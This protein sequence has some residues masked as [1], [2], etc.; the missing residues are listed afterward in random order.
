MF[1]IYNPMTCAC[2]YFFFL[3]QNSYI[4]LLSID[5]LYLIDI[6]L[7]PVS[8]KNIQQSPTSNKDIFALKCR[9]LSLFAFLNLFTFFFLFQFT[10]LSI[11]YDYKSFI[12]MQTLPRA[13]T[14]SCLFSTE[15]HKYKDIENCF[16]CGSLSPLLT[17]KY[18]IS[19]T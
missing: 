16:V 5:D 15:I 8:L 18:A 13:Y 10:L 2:H 19:L 17:R 1:C 11:P 9:Y 14:H 6:A 4:F 3:R 12:H 7:F